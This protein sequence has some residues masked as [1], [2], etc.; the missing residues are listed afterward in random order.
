MRALSH[1]FIVTIIFVTGILF[2]AFFK[3][4]LTYPLTHIKGFSYC[5]WKTPFGEFVPKF[6]W[7][8]VCWGRALDK[9]NLM[10]KDRNIQFVRA[11]VGSIKYREGELKNHVYIEYIKD[12]VVYGYCPQTNKVVY[13]RRDE[14]NY[15]AP[16]YIA[17]NFGY[18]KFNN[19]SNYFGLKERIILEVLK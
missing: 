16:K 14:K 17:G 13:E 18:I 3:Y 4:P 7:D 15:V 10:R 6:F 1:L 19:K 8:D 5:H 11:V 9:L 2:G 12:N